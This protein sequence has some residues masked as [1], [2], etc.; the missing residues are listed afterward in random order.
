MDLWLYR[1]SVR[2]QL[3][4]FDRLMLLIITGC[5][6]TTPLDALRG[7]A[8]VQPII[9]Y[10][11]KVSAR[12]EF[13]LLTTSNII[14]REQVY[15][16]RR[17]SQR[18]RRPNYRQPAAVLRSNLL[19]AAGICSAV[20][21]PRVPPSQWPAPW[22]HQFQFQFNL[23]APPNYEANRQVKHVNNRIPRDSNQ[24]LLVSIDMKAY[25]KPRHL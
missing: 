4:K 20:P 18:S 22:Q 7:L 16:L 25:R 13:Q 3:E 6:R 10:A 21:C 9:S 24:A 12:R 1:A 17:R 14:L 8:G 23:Y 11:H 2:R 15:A 5:L 19:R